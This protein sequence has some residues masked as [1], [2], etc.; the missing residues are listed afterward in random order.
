M[1]SRLTL[2]AWAALAQ[3]A[4]SCAA[5][6][7]LAAPSSPACPPEPTRVTRS[8]GGAVDYLGSVPGIVD[9]CRMRRLDGTGDFYYGAWRSDWPGAGLAYPAILAVV[10]GGTG[11]R[12]SF[13]TRSYPGLQW[14]DTFANEGPDIVTVEGVAYPTFKLAHERSGIEGNTYHS[15]ITSWRDT[16]TGIVLRVVEHQI[17]GQSYGPDTTWQAVRV[18]RLP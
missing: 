5:L 2:Q 13:V 18:E 17:S 12:S 8:T 14:T 15:V 10:A 6:P 4:V 11:T 16:R 9:L 3:L 7:A 1:I